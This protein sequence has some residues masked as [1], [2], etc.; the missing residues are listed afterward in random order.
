MAFFNWCNGRLYSKINCYSSY[1][2][3]QERT[4]K[5][6]LEQGLHLEDYG[7]D[8]QVVPISALKVV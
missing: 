7:G 6:L 4:K 8:V 5:M 2:F 3:K 1:I